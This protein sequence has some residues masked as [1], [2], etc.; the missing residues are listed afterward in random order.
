MIP[1]GDKEGS[2]NRRIGGPYS[3]PTW[4]QWHRWH[5]HYTCSFLL[6]NLTSH[7]SD[8]LLQPD[9]SHASWIFMGWPIWKFGFCVFWKKLVQQFE[10]DTFCITKHQDS[11]RIRLC[12]TM[13]Q[14]GSQRFLD[15]IDLSCI[16]S[17]FL[18]NCLAML[19]WSPQRWTY[20]FQDEFILMLMGKM[21]FV[22]DVF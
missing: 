18:L 20:P 9:S 17:L 22:C 14:V 5:S 8:L 12:W 10:T 15:D 3:T 7:T 21:S 4:R 11:P 2:D 13:M 6:C 19:Y 1:K 16:L